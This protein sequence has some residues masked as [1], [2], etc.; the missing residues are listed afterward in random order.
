MEIA[1]EFKNNKGITLRGFVHEPKKYDTAIIKL[2]GFP[3]ST[4]K[5]ARTFCNAA[6]LFGYLAFRFDFSGSGDS[7]GEFEDKLMSQEVKD[8]R[9]AIDYLAE[10]YKFQHLVLI[11]GSTGAIDAAL[12]AHTDPRVT[13][14]VLIAGLLD[15]KKGATYDFTEEQIQNFEEKG[16]I[17]YD[18]P[19]RWYHNKRLKKA[20]YDEF[21]ALDIEKAIKDYHNPLLVIHGD[22]D[23]GVPVTDGKALYAAANDPKQLVIIKGADHRISK[24]IHKLQ[25]FNH[26]RKFLKKEF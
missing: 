24:W 20:F 1:V 2:H 12:Y 5:S 11:G 25:L 7:D 8:I 23:E 19:D 26:I 13:K 4:G 9:A 16:Y 10:R 21:F 14:L 22:K 17:V 18:R 15:L 3:S 6:N